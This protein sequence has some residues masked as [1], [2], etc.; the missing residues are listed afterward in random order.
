MHQ[1]TQIPKNPL[2]ERCDTYHGICGCHGY[3]RVGPLH[4]LLFS[5]NNLQK[6]QKRVIAL[7]FWYAG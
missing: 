6:P 1:Q 5:L 3:S 7:C 4:G 2:F